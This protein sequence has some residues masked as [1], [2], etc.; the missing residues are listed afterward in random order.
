MAV[1]SMVE[2]TFGIS[3]SVYTE[4]GISYFLDSREIGLFAPFG[5]S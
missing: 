2:P 3:L 4:F 1:N 5:I